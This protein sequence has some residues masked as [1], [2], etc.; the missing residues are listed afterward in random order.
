MALPS[1]LMDWP[2]MALD[3]SEHRNSAA[4]AISS[5]VCARPCSNV[6]RNPSNCSFGLTPIFLAKHCAKLLEQHYRLG[7][8]TW[9]ERVDAHALAGRFGSGNPC[10]AQHSRFRRGICGTPGERRLCRQAGN[11]EDDTGA[12]SVHFREYELA[13]QESRA[14]MDG[15][16]VVEFRQR[17]LFHRNNG[18]VM[19]GVVHQDV[20]TT[21]FSARRADN[22]E[23]SLKRAREV[24]GGEQQLYP[25]D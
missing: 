3:W 19:A 4:L 8:R 16:H 14:Q 2:V 9:A 24:R 10:Q 15:N 22:T 21:K 25:S 23:R 18:T 20:D 17:I 11:I 5:A 6:F 1:T 7:H 13:Q 12:A